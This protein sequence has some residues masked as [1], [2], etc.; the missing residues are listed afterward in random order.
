MEINYYNLF[1]FLHIVFFTTWMAG[2]FYLPR[3][4]VYHSGTKSNSTEYGIFLTMEKKLMKYIM[5]PSMILTWLCGVLLVVHLEIYNQ[6]WL[7][8]KFVLVFIMSVFHMYC[9]RIR[10]N[11][12][13]N[14][15]NKDEKFFRWINEVQTVQFLINQMVFL[16]S[17]L[18]SA[19]E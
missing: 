1:K 14:I 4:Y 13:N 8:L 15:N 19:C 11:F 10:K 16:I 12:E 6:F 2:L 3:L 5:N 9:A 17:G 18:L 7:N